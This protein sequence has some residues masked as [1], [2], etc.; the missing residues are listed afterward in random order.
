MSDLPL[1]HESE[2]KMSS[3]VTGRLSWL[4]RKVTTILFAVLFSA[5]AL[6]FLSQQE[7][8]VSTS[9]RDFS[10]V[11][12]IKPVELDC[13]G[14]DNVGSRELWNAAQEKFKH[15]SDEK[16]TYVWT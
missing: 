12:S 8:F 2:V 16:F 14:R 3:Y 7:Q 15:L 4:S 1:K 9:P 6:V 11:E 10:K 5:A 13:Q